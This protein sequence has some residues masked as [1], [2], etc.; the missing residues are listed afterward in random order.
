[1]LK[2]LHIQRA[3]TFLMICT[4]IIH[5][6]NFFHIYTKILIF[7]SRNKTHDIMKKWL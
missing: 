7:L 6:Y 1:M 3:C 4:L 2:N 5:K